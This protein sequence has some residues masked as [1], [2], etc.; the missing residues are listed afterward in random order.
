MQLEPDDRRV[1]YVQKGVGHYGV[2]A[3]IPIQ[4]G[5]RARI[6][7]FMLLAANTKP[8]VRRSGGKASINESMFEIETSM[9]F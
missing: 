4:I 5:N 3:V 2:F 7:D 6:S 9:L 1:H 8:S